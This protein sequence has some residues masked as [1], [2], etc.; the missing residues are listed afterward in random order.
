MH[1]L[2][3]LLHTLMHMKNGGMMISSGKLK[4]FWEKPASVSLYPPQNSHLSPGIEPKALV[5]E[6]KS[7][8]VL[9]MAW[10]CYDFI[11]NETSISSF[12]VQ[13]R[14]EWSPPLRIA[15]VTMHRLVRP[16]LQL[17]DRD[18]QAWRT[19][20]MITEYWNKHMSQCHFPH[21]K[22]YAT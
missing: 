2:T 6:V 21:Q 22:F 9:A 5:W 1:C 13:L 11:C 18:R 8:T 16:I 19:C 7:T 12:W 14:Q 10:P 3:G 17:R 4:K 15:S 20:Q